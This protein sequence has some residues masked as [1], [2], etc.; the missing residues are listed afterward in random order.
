M[1]HLFVSND[2]TAHGGRTPFALLLRVAGLFVESG[3]E[4]T[5]ILPDAPGGGKC[6]TGVTERRVP[7]ADRHAAD[8]SVGARTLDLP[9]AA[10]AFC[11]PFPGLAWACLAEREVLRAL[12]EQSFDVIHAPDFEAPLYTYQMMRACGLGEAAGPP[13]VIHLLQQTEDRAIANDEDVYAPANVQ[14][15]RAERFSCSAADAWVCPSGW[16]H[17]EL[18]RRHG[19]GADRIAVIPPP[20]RTAG[21]KARHGLW[22]SGDIEPASGVFELARALKTAPEAF[23]EGDLLLLGEDRPYA[24]MNSRRTSEQFVRQVPGVLKPRVHINPTGGVVP[25]GVFLALQRHALAPSAEALEALEAGASVIAGGR[26]GFDALAAPPVRVVPTEWGQLAESLHIPAVD[27]PPWSN[28]SEVAAKWRDLLGGVVTAGAS[29]SRALPAYLPFGGRHGGRATDT[30]KACA[31]GK[32]IAVVIPHYNLSSVL[33]EAVRSA[34]EQSPGPVDVLVVDDG[35]TEPAAA[36]VLAQAEAAGARVL[37]K[38]NAGLSAARNSGLQD[39]LSHLQTPPLGIMFL[40]ADDRLRPGCLGACGT[41]LSNRPEVGV[42]SFWTHHF[43]SVDWY[44]TNVCP[45]LPFQVHS[46]EVATF[47]AYRTEAVLEAGGFREEMFL[48]YED[49]DFTNAIMARGWAAVGLPRVLADYRVRADSM[50]RGMG[51]HAHGLMVRRMLERTPGVLALDPVEVALLGE[52][53]QFQL[54]G[55]LVVLRGMVARWRRMAHRPDLAAKWALDKL[56][57]RLRRK[58][59]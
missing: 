3:D 35:S 2:P 51:A 54:R 25:G 59:R 12:G 6:P 41:V 15:W 39:V 48:G 11:G 14:A 31:S 19:I 32:G 1:R 44:W 13:I 53:I 34:L 33:M 7:W 16:F 55:E 38:R 36:E 22:Y 18:A 9:G 58:Q 46:N 8:R 26:S 45:A 28:A 43:E 52:G 23:P 17:G 50:L 30:R 10:G 4:V 56:S 5:L 20:V 42:V 37:R 27:T 29:R 40:D 57:S 24:P 47:S 49:W 21:A